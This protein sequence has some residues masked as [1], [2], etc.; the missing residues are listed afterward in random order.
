MR[1]GA[2]SAKST[3]N[4]GHQ[5]GMTR[6][7]TEMEHVLST[8]ALCSCALSF[9]YLVISVFPYSGYM[10][11]SLIPSANQENAGS[12]AGLLASAFM[13]GRALTAYHWGKAADMYGRKTILF[14]SLLSSIVFS[15]LFGLSTSFPLALLW[16]FMLY[17]C[18]SRGWPLLLTYLLFIS[19]NGTD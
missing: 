13:M 5:S 4:N 12:Y 17:V 1:Q 19:T 2:S 15:I 18:N 11:I 6:P 9:S 14:A 16:R 8:I 7:L 10:A 3:S